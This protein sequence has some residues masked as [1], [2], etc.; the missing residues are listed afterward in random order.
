M[1]EA[2]RA[3]APGEGV[4]ID[5]VTVV[6]VAELPLLALQARSIARYA[7]AATLGAILVIVNDPDEAACRRGVERLRGEYGKFAGR[8]RVVVPDELLRPPRGLPD[9]LRSLWVSRWRARVKAPLGRSRTNPRG[10]AG[11]NG[12]SMQQAFKLLSVH[13]ATATHLVFLDAKNHFLHPVSAGHFVARDGR[14]RTR[15]VR[16]EEKQR[17]WI[18]DSFAALALPPPPPE[19]APPTV[20]PVAIE[21]AV[22]AR[23][24][25][26]L[27]ERLGPLELFFALRRNGAT[28]F[29]LMFA[30]VDEGEGRWWQVFADGLPASLTVFRR[31]DGAGRDRADML[32]A[33]RGIR[34]GSV[35]LM[36]VHRTQ[37]ERL[38]EAVRE[39]LLALWLERGLLADAAEFERLFPVARH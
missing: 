9:R 15:A 7:D 35:V 5:L 6:F 27:S 2:R 19:R 11:N 32:E 18:E 30:A 38:D 34:R 21:R 4:T 20:T 14:A 10:W 8:L 25:A 37:L 31:L 1:S 17:G 39:E 29:M 3:S 12:W 24:V 28:E 13:V 22:L 36:G 33:V 26:R 16:P 23:C